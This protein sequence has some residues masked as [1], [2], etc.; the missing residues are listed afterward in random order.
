MDCVLVHDSKEGLV[1]L[2]VRRDGRGD[3][4]GKEED[5]GSPMSWILRLTE[6]P[7]DKPHWP[8]VKKAA[9]GDVNPASPAR[10]E[11]ATRKWARWCTEGSV[12]LHGSSLMSANARP[13]T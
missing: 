7:G 3:G 9:G 6:R 2:E 11:T 4:A 1:W 12:L 10:K 13:A 8:M 5:D